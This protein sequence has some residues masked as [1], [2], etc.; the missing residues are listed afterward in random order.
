MRRYCFEIYV[1][2][3]FIGFEN[4]GAHTS[5]LCTSVDITFL[6][7]GFAVAQCNFSFVS[8]F[9]SEKD[10]R[11]LDILNSIPYSVHLKDTAGF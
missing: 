1:G 11:E 2:F 10:L 4:K 9:G 5:K 8:M 7:N 6:H 3:G